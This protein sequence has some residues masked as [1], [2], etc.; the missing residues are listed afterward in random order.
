MKKSDR[1]QVPAAADTGHKPWRNPI[2][3]EHR[4]LGHTRNGAVVRKEKRIEQEIWDSLVK[5]T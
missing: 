4:N 3:G 5:K 2:T 1:S